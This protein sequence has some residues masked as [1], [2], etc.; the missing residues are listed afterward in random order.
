MANQNIDTDNIN[1]LYPKYTYGYSKPVEQLW[2][3]KLKQ[4]LTL[5]IKGEIKYTIIDDTLII[6]IFGVNYL[7][8]RYTISNLSCKIMGGFD[9]EMVAENITKGYKK[10]IINL[11]FNEKVVDK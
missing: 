7:V 1:Q 9:V 3:N 10:Y 5:K 2:A 4:S 6:D 8:Y 11:Y